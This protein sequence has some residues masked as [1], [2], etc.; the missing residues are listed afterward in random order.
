M[1]R[2]EVFREVCARLRVGLLQPAMSPAPSAVNWESMI[3]A[4]SRHNVTPALAYCCRNEQGAPDDVR[5]YL[6]AVL[7]LNTRRNGWLL[8]ALERAVRALA[9]IGVEPVLLK[10]SAALV[11]ELYPALGA[12]VLGDLDL[13]IPEDRARDASRALE[14][15][16]FRRA[17]TGD[18]GAPRHHLAPLIDAA[19]EASVELHTAVVLPEFVEILPAA[20]FGADAIPT[21]FRG[22]RV[23]LPSVTG[24]V[25]HNIAHTA[26]SDRLYDDNDI[27]LRQLLDLVMIRARHENEIDWGELARGFVAARHGRVLST[28]LQHAVELFGVPVPRVGQLPPPRG[29]E[30]LAEGMRWPWVQ[31]GRR[32]VRPYAS[33]LRRNPTWI[34]KWMNPRHLPRRLRRAFRELKP[35]PW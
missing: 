12:R 31:H 25:A 30:A 16:G 35:P 18:R 19:T 7:H 28:S 1:T 24:R 23:R 11:E 34:A 33:W 9:V 3:A 13:L 21:L 20:A 29:M 15:I 4:S 5:E 10:G 2:W 6:A 32:A 8:D 22:L 14:G 17:T 27:E 26:L